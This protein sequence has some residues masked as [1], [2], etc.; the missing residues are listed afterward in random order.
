MVCPY[1]GVVAATL[2]TGEIN[3]DECEGCW[4]GLLT[5]A[6]TE[7]GACIISRARGDP[8]AGLTPPECV[9]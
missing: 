8:V 5:C 6:G 3:G 2:G 4:A 1:G 7:E 9:L